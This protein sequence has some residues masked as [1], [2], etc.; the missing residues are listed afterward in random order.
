[1]S[2]AT[3][4]A[5]TGAVDDAGRVL[6]A[7]VIAY[8]VAFGAEAV[9]PARA[10]APGAI[11][12]AIVDE[13]ELVAA[14]ASGADDVAPRRFL[15]IAF[16]VRAIVSLRRA[17]DASA[18]GVRPR[19]P[20]AGAIAAP[21]DDGQM[22]Y[23]PDVEAALRAWPDVVL[24]CARDGTIVEFTPS[25]SYAPVAPL[26]ER[27]GQ[28]VVALAGEA[29]TKDAVREAL[30]RAVEDR[31]P[32]V[33]ERAGT[34]GG[35]AVFME[36]RFFPAA[37]GGAVVLVRNR[38]DRF[39]AEQDAR[40][41]RRRF[42][43]AFHTR[44]MGM[45]EWATDG[46][47]LDANDAFLE[48]VGYS[49]AELL[50]GAVSWSKMTPEEYWPLEEKAGAEIAATGACTPFRKEYVR[51]DGSRVPI[52]I[53]GALHDME[54]GRGLSFVV[55]LSEQRRLEDEVKATL[56]RFAVVV[57]AT[58]DAVWDWDVPGGRVRWNE[59]FTRM[60]GHEHAD[61]TSSIE[62]WSDAIHPDDRAR[63]SRTLDVAV[64]GDAVSWSDE[65]RFARA[66]GTYAHVADR[67]W[68]LRDAAGRATRA[69]GAMVDVTEKRE[70][71]A[72]LLLADR[73]ASLGTLAAG[74]AH[75]INNP[76]THVVL[77]LDHATRALAVDPPSVQTV[78][79]ALGDARGGAERVRSIVRDLRTFARAEVDDKQPVDVREAVEWATRI[80]APALRDKA[81]LTAVYDDVPAV[82]GDGS[83]LAQVFVNLLV[84]AAQALPDGEASR[85]EVK[86][87]V[88]AA[89]DDWVHVEVSD[90]GPGIP[91]DV[92]GRIFDPF[93]TTK[94]VGEGTG[95]GL[96]ICHGILASMGGRIEVA[97]EVGRGTTF[98]V[99]LPA[100]KEAPR[101]AP[102]PPPTT[103]PHRAGR[104][105]IIDDD[106]LTRS[107]IE[108]TLR[109][110]HEV[111]TVSGGRE[112]LSLLE[113]G[114]RFDVVFSDLMMPDMTG[115]ELHAALER[116]SPELAARVVFLT[117]GAFTSGAQRFLE[118][119]ANACLEKPFDPDALLA[120]T[121]RRVAQVAG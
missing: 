71:A 60:F 18:L 20:A 42:E 15:E 91:T 13:V 34:L 66:D 35:V 82:L 77:S 9:A 69:I 21:V 114:A 47:I 4:Y 68:I 78:V 50:G 45:I 81:R 52:F 99:R 96:S 65:Y 64:A 61:G 102:P 40:A 25:P 111:V 72:R 113:R 32:A 115:M 119:T 108:R 105:L 48:M 94:G 93:F 75:E 57:R 11:L 17:A 22:R 103:G 1:M 27:I 83:R 107:L 85:H 28:N 100:T 59:S 51:K 117:A 53:G 88:A 90:D 36:V 56:E 39:R 98:R 86:V 109:I 120:F 73:L 92:I 7:P 14:V 70:L 49:R 80:A 55:D 62:W 46:R 5:M 30:R 31:E 26:Q 67:G 19:R 8:V 37:D 87:V 74:V 54:R 101:R 63:V 121:R 23:A 12:L 29:D 97:S 84:N 33:V 112:A 44:M 106:A 2:D 10:A 79:D 24:R 110:E 118:Q 41:S 95:L 16:P 116:L 89:A 76:L 104:V 38:V 6:V 58:T 3:T 43:H